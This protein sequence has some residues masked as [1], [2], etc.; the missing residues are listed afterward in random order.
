[1]CGEGS[2]SEG[3]GIAVEEAAGPRSSSSPMEGRG[4]TKRRRFFMDIF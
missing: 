1:M 2:E 4:S 3:S